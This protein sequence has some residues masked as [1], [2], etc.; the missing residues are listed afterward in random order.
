MNTSRRV[1]Q[2]PF[3][4][5]PPSAGGLALGEEPVRPVIGAPAIDRSLNWIDLAAAQLGPHEFRRRLWHFAPGVLSL[6]GC[7]LLAFAHPAAPLP[8]IA[9]AF[10][11]VGVSVAAI[12]WNDSI[13]RP[14]EWHCLQSILGYSVSVI[15]LFAFFPSRPEL[16]LTV[17]GIVA[18]GDGC[19]TL[20]G[21]L[22]GKRKLPWNA[23]K[24]WAG[25][26]AFVLAAMPLAVFI[27]WCG[28]VPHPSVVLAVFCVAPAVL[29]AAAVETL[30]MHCNDNA[31]VGV[32]AAAVV[33]LMHGLVVGWW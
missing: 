23:D 3:S 26:I 14:G 18:F 12:Y 5:H 2:G 13:R 7:S 22:A 16:A 15:P 28:S 20:V 27:Y 21:L 6:L 24:T 32:S 8:A 17:A 29:A 1:V 25:T 30:P 19:A 11:A 31:F 10:L 33:I 4:G 9:M